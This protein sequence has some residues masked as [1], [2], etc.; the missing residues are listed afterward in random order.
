MKNVSFL[1][2]LSFKRGV[3]AQRSE[4]KSWEPR[5]EILIKHT[6]HDL[7]NQILINIQQHMKNGISYN[8]KKENVWYEAEH[9]HQIII[10]V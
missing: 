9:I 6:Q 1:Y 5:G 4:K 10:K 2:S 7:E 3:T 8:L